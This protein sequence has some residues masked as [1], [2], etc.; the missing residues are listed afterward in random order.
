[1]A[2]TGAPGMAV[3]VGVRGE[4]VWSEG[5]GYADLEQRVPVWPAVTRFRIGSVSKPF[6]ALAVAQL[7]EQG[8]LDLDAP[9]QQYVLSFPQK[10]GT[11]TT[12]MLAGH[13]AGVRHYANAEEFLSQTRYDTV[14]DGLEI[15]ADDTLLHQP[16]SAYSYSSY[17]WNLISAVV[18]GASQQDFL[19]YMDQHVFGPLG[20]EHTVADLVDSIVVNRTRYYALVDGRIVNAPPVDNSNKWAGGGFLSTSEDLVRFGFGHL[21]PTVVSEETVQL[22]WTKQVTTAG[23]SIPYGIGWQVRRDDTGH[24]WVGHSGG[25]VGGSTMLLSYS[26]AEVVV[27]TIANMGGARCPDLAPQLA[28]LFVPREE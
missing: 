18:E 11:V 17:G 14:L 24:Q 23:D 1:M 6:T 28:N 5:F 10:R 22:L 13:L 7:Y 21:D 9:V 19:G 26:D 27:A 8:K 4:L 2:E 20:M 15:F 16:G 3:S 12:R 25:S